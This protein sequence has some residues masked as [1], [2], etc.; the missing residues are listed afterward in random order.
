MEPNIRS[1]RRGT[2]D[3]NRRDFLTAMLAAPLAAA[4]GGC[5][6]KSKTHNSTEHVLKNVIAYHKNYGALPSNPVSVAW[7]PS[8][9]SYPKIHEP[10]SFAQGRN[11]VY[12]LVARSLMLLNST[13]PENPLEELIK[14]GDRVVIK[15]NWCSQYKFPF[16]I[17]HPSIIFPLVEFSLKAGASK[18]NIVEAPMTLSAGCNWFWSS[19]LIGSHSLAKLL[20]ELHD[21]AEV[22][23]VDGNADDFIWVDVGEASELRAFGIE[24]L[25]HDGHTGFEKNMFFDTEDYHGYNPRMY[26]PGLAAIARSY[27]DCDVF[28]NA[29]KLKTHLWTGLTVALKNLMGLNLRSTIH[30][31]P[32]DVFRTYEARP[33]IKHY[34]ESPLRDI[35]HF[36]RIKLRECKPGDPPAFSKLYYNGPGNDVLWRTLADLNKI[37]RFADADG[38]MQNKPQRKYLT[39]VDGI[40]G[41]DKN[42]PI[43]DSLVRSGCII[44]GSDPVCV[45]AVCAYIM[46]WDP[47][48]LNLITECSN[49]STLPIGSSKDFVQNIVGEDT[50]SPCFSQYFKPPRTYQQDVLSPHKLKLKRI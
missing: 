29:P 19:A 21:G 20:S 31:M 42:G 1:T 18:V 34:R 30:R 24:A 25:D 3:L 26:R 8:V 36:N 2:M 38:R 17:T 5:E 4:I 40:V 50:N 39:V 16:P 9:R 10:H 48:V 44:A 22:N 45:D 49:V 41:T 32:P 46:G 13:N 33:D 23:F 47:N 35:P 37:I 27:L 28:I 15:P 11:Q 7:D 6:Q 14:P 12:P 43:S